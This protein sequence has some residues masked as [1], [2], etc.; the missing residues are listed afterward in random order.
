MQTDSKSDNLVF[1]EKWN[2]MYR[3]S[4]GP[5]VSHFFRTLKEEAKL[6]GRFC[7]K[8]ERVLM[9]PRSFCDRD[10]VET[11]RWNDV[12]PGGTLETF[13]TVYRGF[14]GLPDPPY[15][16]GYVLLDGASTAILNYIRGVDLTPGSD[17]LKAL[18]IGA[19]MRVVY[20]PK[21]ESKMSDFWFE[22]A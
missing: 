16:F 11:E 21:R 13:T 18:K 5:I 7:P 12:G 4:A 1:E 2:L 3:H 22:P 20:A 15:C 6:V 9:P 17:G 19:R 10:F 14:Q 8:C